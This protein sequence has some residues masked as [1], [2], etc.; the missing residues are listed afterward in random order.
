M[1][2]AHTVSDTETE[3]PWKETSNPTGDRTS[4]AT[5][6]P[7]R[8]GAALG[9]AGLSAPSTWYPPTPGCLTVSVAQENQSP[10]R[11]FVPE[12]LCVGALIPNHRYPGV[13]NRSPRNEGACLAGVQDSGTHD[14]CAQKL[15][16]NSH[17]P[18]GLGTH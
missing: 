17:R 7:W 9:S 15:G 5:L 12:H 2:G 18:V 13:D 8:V 1:L 10:D 6:L 3:Q 4:L 16:P 11:P 14:L